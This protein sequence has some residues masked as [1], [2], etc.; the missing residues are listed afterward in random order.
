[1][2]STLKEKETYYLPKRCLTSEK[3]HHKSASVSTDIPSPYLTNN[4]ELH[5]NCT[6]NQFYTQEFYH[7]RSTLLN[8]TQ[9]KF[10]VNNQFMTLNNRISLLKKKKDLSKQ[11]CMIKSINVK[12]FLE[13]QRTRSEFFHEKQRVFTN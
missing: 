11:R 10:H 13:K 12:E 2:C 8:L 1:M 5:R 6:Q 4:F 7:S 9:Q 3:H